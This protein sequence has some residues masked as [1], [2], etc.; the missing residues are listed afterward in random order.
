MTRADSHGVVTETA[1]TNTYGRK[2]VAMEDGKGF[3]RWMARR[4]ASG[5]T[6]PT[7]NDDFYA[8]YVAAA[9][10]ADAERDAGRAHEEV[11]GG[12]VVPPDMTDDEAYRNLL[13]VVSGRAARRQALEDVRQSRRDRAEEHARHAREMGYPLHWQYEA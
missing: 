2:D 4:A 7:G 5:A 6:T 10:G 3:E 8:Q 13:D 9:T 11:P 1:T 12:A